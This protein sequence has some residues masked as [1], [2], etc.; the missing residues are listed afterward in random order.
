MSVLDRIKVFAA[1][2][3]MVKYLISLCICLFITSV[4][5]PYLNFNRTRSGRNASLCSSENDGKC[6]FL[7][8]GDRL[9]SEAINVDNGGDQSRIIKPL[10]PDP[11]F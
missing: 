10:V 7:K 3:F 8:K 6:C 9:K 5:K 1:I 2:Y 4:A 11:Q